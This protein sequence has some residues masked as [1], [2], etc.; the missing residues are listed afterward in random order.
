MPE[1]TVGMKTKKLFWNRVAIRATRHPFAC[2]R[3]RT[4]TA[5]AGLVQPEEEQAERGPNMYLQIPEGWVS[6]GWGQALFGG[7]Q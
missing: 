1:D 2:V 6:G 3:V 5:L 4:D 7:A